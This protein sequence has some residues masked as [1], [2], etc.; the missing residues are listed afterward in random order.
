MP[1]RTA[2]TTLGSSSW[3]CL[4]ATSMLAHAFAMRWRRAT[5]ELYVVT[6][7]KTTMKIT[8]PTANPAA[9]L[10]GLMSG[11]LGFRTSHDQAAGEEQAQHGRRGD[12]KDSAEQTHHELA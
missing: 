3:R 9:R 11:R 10:T 12:R 8:R 5:T 1:P 2:A 6:S 7:M 4:S